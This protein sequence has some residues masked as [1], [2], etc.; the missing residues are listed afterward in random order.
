MMMVGRSR[1]T[2]FNIVTLLQGKAWD[3][4]EDI[5]MDDLQGE[6]GYKLVFDRLDRGFQC[7]EL[8]ELP[9]DFEQYFIKLH[10][11]GSQTLQQYQA[12]FLKAERKLQVTHG[13]TSPRRC[14][15]GGT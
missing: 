15:H 10:R 13:V 11:K 4:I 12:E 5:P 14:G 2:V 6:E 8:T 3:L 1:E 7:D 9:D